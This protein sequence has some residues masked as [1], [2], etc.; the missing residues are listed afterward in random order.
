MNIKR[1]KNKKV[2]SSYINKKR[3]WNALNL[4]LHFNEENKIYYQFLL[5]DKDTFRYSW[6][7]L[8]LEF[9]MVGFE[10]GSCGYYDKDKVFNGNT[11]VQFDPSNNIQFLHRNLIK[12][13]STHHN[14]RV[15]KIIKHYTTRVQKKEYIIGYNQRN[16]HAYIDLNG[17]YSILSFSKLQELEDECIAVLIHL[18]DSEPYK[19]FLLFSTL[20]SRHSFSYNK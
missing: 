17:N 1:A 3:C 19:Q 6:M 9:Y 14:E 4:C 8:K 13:H 5:G 18:R 11:M 10:V 2:A 16:R 15:W 7:A 20:L 12:W